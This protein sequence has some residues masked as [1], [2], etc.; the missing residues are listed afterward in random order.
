MNF[1]V[2]VI[3]FPVAYQVYASF[4]EDA[5]QQRVAEIAE[6]LGFHSLD[7]LPMVRLLRGERPFYD[8][9]HATPAVNREIAKVVARALREEVLA[10]RFS[11]RPVSRPRADE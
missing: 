11:D 6:G 5:P 1:E 4:L 10:S 8:Q 9:C 7:L 3:I 2:L